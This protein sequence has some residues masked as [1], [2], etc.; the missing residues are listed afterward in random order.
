MRRIR[1]REDDD[2]TDAN[3][4]QLLRQI[5]AHLGIESNA[6]TT[7]SAVPAQSLPQVFV[8]YRA[9]L[10]ASGK[11][12]NTVCNYGRLLQRASQDIDLL[13]LDAPRV[14]AWGARQNVRLSP[15]SC[16]V[17]YAAMRSWAEFTGQTHAVGA[18]KARPV[19][20]TPQ[21][22]P[23]ESDVERLRDALRP[24]KHNRSL[25]ATE[26]RRDG[27]I[28]DLLWEGALRISEVCALDLSHLRC[29]DERGDLRT[30]SPGLS[31]THVWVDR[32]KRG[33]SRL[34]PLTPE[35]ARSLRNYV[36][37][38]RPS[39]PPHHA[40]AVFT[41]RGGARM[42]PKTYSQ[43]LDD[44][45]AR[46]GVTTVR[47]RTHNGRRMRITDLISNGAMPSAVIRV[48]GHKSLKELE[49]YINL[50]EE[51]VEREWLM[52]PLRSCKSRKSAKKRGSG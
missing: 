42:T 12:A 28:F 19:D 48:T 11:S 18:L 50:S 24:S 14:I 9:W 40:T 15:R 3:D 46:I 17:L 10:G 33:K 52:T 29:R 36:E 32:S 47:G 51:V 5:A 30:W 22:L 27:A 31:L 7:A 1:S 39:G 26:L 43:R 25:K 20:P 35:A 37:V 45:G 13:A 21:A 4:R 2:T 49:P 16:H 38:H 44:L 23:P 8:E 41:S 34:V 6:N